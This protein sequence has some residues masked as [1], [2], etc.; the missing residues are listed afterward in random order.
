MGTGKVKREGLL[1]NGFHGRH[2]L[3]GGFSQPEKYVLHILVGVQSGF[4]G[5]G[6]IEA[7]H[8]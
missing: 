6:F 8:G 2:A 1:A 3:L 4:A 5:N 7:K